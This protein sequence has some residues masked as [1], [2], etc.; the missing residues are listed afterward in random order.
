M[1]DPET[2]RLSRLI[3][4]LTLLQTK[5]LVTAPELAQRF[6]VSV[7]TI[8]RDLKTLENGG[9][10]LLTEEGRGYRLLEGYRLPP[11]MLT[12]PQANAIVTAQQLLLHQ[13][14]SLLV[15][16]EEAV[17]KIKAVLSLHTREKANL[18]ESRIK[19][20]PPTPAAGKSHYL[21]WLQ[22]ALTNYQVVEI[23]Y[24][25]PTDEATCRQVEPFALL[26]SSQADWLLV[27][28]C[29]LR[30]GF[31][32]FR[33]DRIQSLSVLAQHFEPHRLTLQQ[34]FAQHA[35]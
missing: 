8:Y 35:K 21:S 33:L 13:D 34:Y 11:V 9:I 26:L 1:L 2:K 24:Q 17:Q 32:I 19:A 29:Q 4:L 15:A 14:A 5:R 28:W 3:A 7:R 25:S 30:Q 31:R 16:Y 18:L 12:E 27:G 20:Y 6:G 10:P 23:Q 22:S